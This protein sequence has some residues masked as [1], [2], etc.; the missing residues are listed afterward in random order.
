[1][2][3]EE[4]LQEDTDTDTDS[5]IDIDSDIDTDIDT[6]SD[7]DDDGDARRI[8]RLVLP[9]LDWYDEEG[10]INKDALIE[11]FN[12]IEA[13]LNELA[14]IS[15]FEVSG[16]DFNTFNYN[17]STLESDDDQAVNLKSLIDIL[18]IKGFPIVCK[19]D[20]KVLTKLQYYDDDYNLCTITDANL[21]ALGTNGQIWVYLDYSENLVYISSDATNANGDVLI[22]CYD[23]GVVHSIGG[24]NLMDVNILQVL[25]DMRRVPVGYGSLSEVA[26]RAGGTDGKGWGYA[27]YNGNRSIGVV[28]RE[29]GGQNYPLTFYDFGV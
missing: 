15:P 18:D 17:D 28:T 1:M 16:P 13:K 8:E 24:L 3:D 29:S 25:A 19:F 11:N 12:A 27:A 21:S 26:W 4:I 5:D 7:T 6:D 9:R 2:P 20:N 14:D 23:N 10:R 22:A